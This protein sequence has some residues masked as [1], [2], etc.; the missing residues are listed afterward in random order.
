MR[1]LTFRALGDR[2]H[3]PSLQTFLLLL[4]LPMLLMMMMLGSCLT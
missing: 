2:L 4:L 1:H 3:A